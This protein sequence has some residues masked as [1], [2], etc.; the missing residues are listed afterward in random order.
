MFVFVKKERE[1]KKDSDTL[2][3]DFF[4]NV[5]GNP[6]GLRLVHLCVI[7]MFTLHGEVFVFVVCL[8]VTGHILAS[9]QFITHEQFS[10]L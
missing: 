5:N 3:I 4:F 8:K 10:V 9:V 2:Q 6:L 1:F 7:V